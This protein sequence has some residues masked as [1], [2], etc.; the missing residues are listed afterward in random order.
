MKKISVITVVFLLAF[1][2]LAGTTRAALTQ[3]QVSQLYVS[4][5]GRASEGEGNAYWVAKGATM[6]STATQMLGSPAAI[7][8]FG[9]SAAAV[10]QS[11][12]YDIESSTYSGKS[13]V[14]L[15]TLIFH[16]DK[17]IS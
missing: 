5:F 17:S 12:I 7:A 4:I 15:P 6:A 16:P 8:Y 9:N 1:A 10:E 2:L 3:T 13:L 14:E 11:V